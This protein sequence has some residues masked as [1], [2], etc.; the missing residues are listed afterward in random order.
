VTHGYVVRRIVQAVPTLLGLSL[1]VFGLSAFA[2][3]PAAQLAAQGSPDGEASAEAIAAI[4]QELGLDRP[5]PVRYGRWL[6]DALQGDLGT[7]LFTNRTVASEVLRGLPATVVLAGTSL[8]LIVVLAVPVGVAGA[9]FHRRWED[10]VVRVVALAGASVPAFSLAYVLVDVFAVRLQL[11]P[12]AGF[13][14]PASV[15]LPALALA[16]GPAAMV[17]RLLRAALL[18]VLGENYMLTAKAKGLAALPT[19]VRH[20]VRNAALPV[21]TVLGGTL[22]RMLE[23]AVIIE[24]VFAWPG[25]GLLTYNGIIAHDYPV[26]VGTVLFGGG[27]FVLLNL[28]VD[29][30]YAL[31]DPRVRVGAQA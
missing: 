16:V 7:S 19:M 3:S 13:H 9:L 23:G 10:Q 31:V 24:V 12:V 15:V 20:G 17:S 21:L 27:V 5:L 6:S 26:V 29:L 8:A 28:A 30:S 11:L 14:G 1:L 18:D 25:I 4:N 2:G 22:G